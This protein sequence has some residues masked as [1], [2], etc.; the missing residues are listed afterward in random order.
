VGKCAICS[1]TTGL[2]CQSCVDSTRGPEPPFYCNK[3]H[4]KE[5]WIAGHKNTCGGARIKKFARA[6]KRPERPV[7]FLAYCM[8]HDR[9]PHPTMSCY[10]DYGFAN[11]K[12]EHE[13]ASLMS[14][15]V[16]LIKLLECDI[17]DVHEACITGKLADLIVKEYVTARPDPTT[18]GGYFPW[19][20]ANQ[21]IVNN[22]YT[23]A[24]PQ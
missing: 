12:D 22:Q 6:V 23:T 5:H 18:R 4:Q 3:E 9:L 13:E 14:V 15:Y 2:R 20:E 11:C 8:Y 21:A 19:F 17:D 24:P 7:D 10:K 1:K 16:G